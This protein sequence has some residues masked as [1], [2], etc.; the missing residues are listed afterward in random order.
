MLRRRPVFIC[1]LAVKNSN[2]I[3]TC[4]QAMKAKLK[5]SHVDQL[6]SHLK[7]PG[8]ISARRQTALRFEKLAQLSAA[9]DSTIVRFVRPTL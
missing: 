1:A 9:S 5:I 2:T 4:H 7:L 6:P 3:V 8:C